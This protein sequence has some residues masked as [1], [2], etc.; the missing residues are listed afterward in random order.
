[1]VS[2][3]QYGMLSLTVPS[4]MRFKKKPSAFNRC[5]GDKMRNKDYSDRESVQ[6]A[7]RAATKACGR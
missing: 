6:T 7:F 3:K 4:P 2:T 1:M 5:V